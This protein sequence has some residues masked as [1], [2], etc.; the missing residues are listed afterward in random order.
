[1][2]D[3][4]VIGI[5]SRPSNNDYEK[6]RSSTISPSPRERIGGNEPET[7]PRDLI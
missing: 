5:V 3:E 4:I 2:D 1:M 6:W 7:L